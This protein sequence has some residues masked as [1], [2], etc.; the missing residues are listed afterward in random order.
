[1]VSGSGLEDHPANCSPGAHR[2]GRAL[3][4]PMIVKFQPGSQAPEEELDSTTLFREIRPQHRIPRLGIAG[5]IALHALLIW[6][7]MFG[8]RAARQAESP[9]LYATMIAPEEKKI[10][11]YK[12]AP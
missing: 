10:I 11:W 8:P 5:S 2:K 4:P 1:M 6:F 3:I 7:A 9:T 12:P